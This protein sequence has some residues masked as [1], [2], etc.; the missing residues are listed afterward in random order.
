MPTKPPNFR[1]LDQ[2]VADALARALATIPLPRRLQARRF[3]APWYVEAH[4]ESFAVHDA[5]GRVLAFIYFDEDEKRRD[6]AKRLTREEARRIAIA[7]AR[8]P[9]LLT[10]ERARSG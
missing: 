7:I 5:N 8:L 3:P 10:A 9:E 6:I 1:P 4:T 2:S